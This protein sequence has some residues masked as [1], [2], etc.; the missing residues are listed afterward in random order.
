V[1]ARVL[2]EAGLTTTSI[3]LLREHTERVKPPRA[4]F[5]PYAFGRPLG[6]PDDRA[7]QLRVLRAALALTEAPRGPVLV[8]FADDTFAD[9]VNLPQAATVSA[10]AECGLAATEVEALRPHYERWVAAHGGR[11]A[12]GLAGV[13]PARLPA[14]VACLQAYADGAEMDLPERPPAVELPQYLRWCADDLKAYYFEAR[15]SQVPD[16][17]FPELHR[18]FWGQTAG[19]ALCVAVRDRLKAAGDPQLDAVAFGIAR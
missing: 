3:S 8:D 5:V 16:A 15:L 2:E 10:C 14:L 4:L 1:I 17:P 11:T 12:V 13:A 9:D 18:W 7:L 6:R 19:G